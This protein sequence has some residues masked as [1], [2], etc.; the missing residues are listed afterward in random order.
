[1]KTTRA[2]WSPAGSE[3][4]PNNQNVVTFT[5]LDAE[6]NAEGARQANSESAV[7]PRSSLSLEEFARAVTELGLANAAELEALTSIPPRELP[8]CRAA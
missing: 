5:L 4:S 3:R 2:M 6:E 1:M 8:A 7:R